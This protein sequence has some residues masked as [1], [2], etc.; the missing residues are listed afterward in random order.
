M[1]RTFLKYFFL[2]VFLILFGDLLNPLSAQNYVLSNW[3]VE[4]G[5]SSNDLQDVFQDDAGFMWMATEHGLNKFDGYS[6]TKYRYHPDDSTSI[7]ANFINNICEDDL[8]NIWINLGVGVLSKYDKLSKKFTNYYFPERKT[9]ISEVQFIQGKGIVIATNKG[10]FSM[11]SQANKLVSWN[12]KNKKLSKSIYKI[13]PVSPQQLYLSTESGLEILNLLSYSLEPTYLVG[14]T[15]TVRFKYPMDKL[16]KDANGELWLQSANRSLVHSEKGVY[17][18]ISLTGADRPIYK[19]AG[20]LSIFEDDKNVKWFFDFKGQLS[21]YNDQKKNWE[22]FSPQ[23]ESVAFAFI[24]K[25]DKLWVCTK[26]NELYQ[27]NGEE[28]MSIIRLDNQLKHWEISH[29]FVDDKNGVW[30]SSKKKG[31]WRIYNRKWPINSI[32][33][34]D[35]DFPINFDIG[36][37]M[38]EDQYFMWLGTYNNLYRYYFKTETLT[39]LFPNISK[40]NPLKGFMI[41]DLEKNINGE[42]WIATNNGIV[43]VEKNEKDY[44]YLS[45]VVVNNKTV[46]LN[47]VRCIRSDQNGQM[48]LGTNVGLFAYNTNADQFYLYQ[49]SEK[50]KSSIRSNAI[51]CIAI[52]DET[53]ILVGY[54][55]EGVDLVT[56]NPVDHSISSQKISY[57]NEKMQQ[58][59]L[60]TA[61]TFHLSGTDN[62]VGTFSKGLLKLD[63]KN[64]TMSPLSNEFPIIPNIKS[65]QKGKKGNLW[66]SSIDGIR[67]VNPKDLTYYRF[68]K[69]SGLLSNQFYINSSAQD[70]SGNLYFGGTKGINEIQPSNWNNQDTIA[71]PILTDFKK[72]DQS[73]TFEMNLDEVKSIPLSHQDDYVTFEFVS[74]T[75]DNPGDVQYA[76][77][78]DGFDENWRYCEN[79]LSAT[80]TNLPPG[81]YQFRVRAGNKGGFLNSKTKSVDIIVAAPFWQS[82]WFICLVIGLLVFAY[83]LVFKIQS[84]RRLD[85]LKIIAGVRKKAADD[86]HDEL[87]HRL[88]KIVL[89]VESLMLRKDTFPKES[90]HTL[91][92]IQENANELYYS[93]KDFIW[94]M[95]PSK[96]SAMD[97]FILL[98]DFGD[99]LFADTSIQ[100]SVEGIRE[101]YKGYLLNMDWK[102]QLIMIFKEA[103]N[104]ALKHSGANAVNLK[105]NASQKNLKIVLTDNGKGFILNHEKFGYGLGSMINRSKKIGGQLEIKTLPE[106]GTE[107][108]FSFK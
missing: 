85:R 3:T 39:P 63:L 102:R 72:Y 28:W 42:L 7:G 18:R 58:Y 26:T 77:Q 16:Y 54:I 35:S 27:W 65:I 68:S 86:F 100:F 67:S 60:M 91:R 15:D 31:I 78:L 19:P 59:D 55:K 106:K 51:Q 89:F 105:I 64:L 40:K 50:A 9:F 82:S 14:K 57:V 99:E 37:L 97:L 87:G 88:T 48:W 52:V 24:D 74:P 104:N 1:L 73:I 20:H 62:W 107:V 94:A 95:N 76:F 45:S 101:E 4:D 70:H 22:S 13:F 75:F 12:L 90:A 108:L 80:Y 10:I 34:S 66:V 71:T 5:L 93:T 92:K 46:N 29:V 11:D 2:P 30:L 25:Q 44:R 61:N 98:R 21:F 41:N 38:I 23:L 47:T 6:F 103:M 17:F 32:Q 36:A 96:D 33:N 53:D 49:F 43:I 84:K 56:Y 81:N 79:Q 69:A 8:G 83:W